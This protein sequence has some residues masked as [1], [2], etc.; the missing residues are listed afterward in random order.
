MIELAGGTTR[1]LIE[2]STITKVNVEKYVL[3]LF[4]SNNAQFMFPVIL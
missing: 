1:L 2:K 4:F 3:N